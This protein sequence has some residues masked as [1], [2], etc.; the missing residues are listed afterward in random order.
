MILELT[1][2]SL[3]NT[4][5]LTDIPS[6]I[7]GVQASATTLTAAT[8]GAS[9]GDVNIS[10]T[11]GLVNKLTALAESVCGSSKHRKKDQESC[12]YS[13]INEASTYPELSGLD[14]FISLQ[15]V[16]NLVALAAEAGWGGATAGSPTAQTAGILA[17]I[18]WQ[19]DEIKAIPNLIRTSAANV[20]PS[21]T[22]STNA[23]SASSNAPCPTGTD[24]A[25]CDDTTNCSVQNNKCTSGSTLV[26]YISMMRSSL[27]T[28]TIPP[29]SHRSRLF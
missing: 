5:N 22:P 2:E 18:W 1:P 25:A 19:W 14:V 6:A 4:E 10:L 23:A 13:F 29:R 8:D 24:I 21:A 3:Q 11:P 28:R 20:G 9:V 27:F 12:A 17:I 26:V 16:A 15:E 7:T